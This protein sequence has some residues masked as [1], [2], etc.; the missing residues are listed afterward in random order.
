MNIL[1]VEDDPQLARVVQ[2]G[3]LEEGH[4]VDLTRDGATGFERAAAHDYDVILLDVLLPRMDGFEITQR[5]REQ[6]VRT[7]IL[8][9]TARDAVTY[10]VHGL[11]IGAD[12]YLVK[13]FAF[14]ELSARARALVRRAA[15][16]ALQTVLHVG[17]LEVDV[18]RRLVTRADRSVE[19]TS[20]EFDLLVYLM[21][22]AGL[23]V[24][25]AQIYDHV[26]GSTTDT[27]SNVVDLYIH[28]VRQKVDRDH[29]APLLRTVRGVGYMI[30][31]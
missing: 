9:L 13:P 29:V 18:S 15:P 24:S 14:E 26:W 12:D 30:K 31:A 17:D 27:G 4:H 3:L 1:L 20:R 22:N 7:P 6:H 8:L 11:D 25:R 19:L 28:Y 10:R 21:R 2:R 5:L 16:E 23:V